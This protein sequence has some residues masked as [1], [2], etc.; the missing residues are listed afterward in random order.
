MKNKQWTYIL[1]Y[2]YIWNNVVAH[3]TKHPPL[4]KNIAVI[5]NNMMMTT[6]LIKCFLNL[7]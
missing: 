4:H 7:E 5:K 3:R 6:L 2:N 1:M